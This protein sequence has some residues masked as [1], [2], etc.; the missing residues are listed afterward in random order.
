MMGAIP[1]EQLHDK[2][3]APVGSVDDLQGKT[4][5]LQGLTEKIIEATRA[6]DNHANVMVGINTALF[7]LVITI[8]FQVDHL[9]ITLGIIAIF[10]AASAIAAVFAIRLPHMLAHTR[11]PESVFYAR[12]IA[13]YPSA[14]AYAAQLRAVIADDEALFLQYAREAYNLST[15]YYIPKR[16]ML[17]W[18][19]YLFVFG[20][21]TSALFLVLE[22]VHWFHLF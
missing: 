1:M 14:D 13:S 22:K 21:V 11:H 16:R 9:K 6:V 8:L 15:Y 3:V 18:S 17:S 19:R 5:F 12:H 2:S 20:V 10:S 4:G 7:A